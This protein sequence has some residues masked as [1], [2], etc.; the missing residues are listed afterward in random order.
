MLLSKKVDFIYSVSFSILM[1][2][3]YDFSRAIS[4]FSTLN[5]SCS[6]SSIA[7][8]ILSTALDI[9]L[10][11]CSWLL[12]ITWPASLKLTLLI[13]LVWTCDGRSTETNSGALK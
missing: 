12:F 6:I 2:T 4:S 3:W 1:I 5:P 13:L 11:V 10:F 7:F 9:L 8:L